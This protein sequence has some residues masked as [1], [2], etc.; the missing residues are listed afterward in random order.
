MKCPHCGH[1]AR[2]AFG[3]CAR[4]GRGL[5]NGAR[6]AIHLYRDR[7]RRLR[8][9]RFARRCAVAAA[10]LLALILAL[11]LLRRAAPAPVPDAAPVPTAT[12]DPTPEPTP[13]PYDGVYAPMAN[14]ATAEELIELYR[15]MIDTG[16]PTVYLETLALGEAEIADITDKFSNYFDRYR[17]SFDPPSI[18]VE[19][20]A[21]LRALHAIQSGTLD[22]LDEDARFVAD[23]ALAAVGEALQPGMTD[24]EKELALHDY[25]VD[26]S[27][28][29][30]DPLSPHSGDALGLFRYGE[31]RCAGY[32]DAF[33]LLGKLAGLEVEMIGGPTSRDEAGAKGHAWSL[34]RLDGLWYVVDTT[35]DDLIEAEPTLEHTFFN[36]PFPCFGDSRSCDARF[37]PEGE[38]AQALDDKYYF[39]RPEYAAD[40]GEAALASAIRQLDA[41][42]TAYLMLPDREMAQSLSQAL[43]KH[44]GRKGQCFELSE[45]LTFNLFRFR[46]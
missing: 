38:W 46:L 32:C 37:L 28:Y 3:V 15:W 4:C 33:R 14:I 17:A 7:R 5:G 9:Q 18:R 31:C 21:G 16:S 13:L 40:T 30:L 27:A 35:W 36:V 43:A 25:V 11:F 20:K 44:Y 42:G 2:G 22:A 45:D 6:S 12:P 1:E 23:A 26:H 29:A 41:D 8:R 34:V 39:N 24:W 19:L 10:L